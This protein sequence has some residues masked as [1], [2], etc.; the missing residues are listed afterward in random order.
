MAQ[1]L[2]YTPTAH[3]VATADEDWQR[4]LQRLHERG[5]LRLASALAHR[6]PEVATLLLRQLDT[7]PG[8]RS[9]ATLSVMAEALGDLDPEVVAR[10]LDAV[11]LG[12]AEAGE[13]TR[14]EPPGM[15]ALLGRSNDEDVRRGL[16][17]ALV[18][19]G[20]VGRTLGAG[21]GAGEG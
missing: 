15:F 20:A 13:R 3:P 18:F 11:K 9:A 2:S 8:R 19:L 21:E 1:P 4:L 7:E 6:L 10:L 5:L 17:A 16:W 14:G 12:A